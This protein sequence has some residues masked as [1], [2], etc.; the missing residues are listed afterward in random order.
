MRL[1]KRD[2]NISLGLKSIGLARI[3]LLLVLLSITLIM[4]VILHEQERKFAQVAFDAKVAD[5]EKTL[6]LRMKNYEEMLLGVAGLYE[7]SNS[8][9]R[10]EFHAYVSRLHILTNYVGVLGVGYAQWI[11]PENL[12]EHI[13]AVKAEGFPDFTVRPAGIRDHYTS[14][15]YIEP[16]EGRNLAAF[17]Y[18]MYSETVRRTAM[19]HAVSNNSTSLSAKVTLVQES[20]VNVQ[21]GMLMYHPVYKK[22]KPL[23]T[24]AQRWDALD[25]FAYSPFRVNDLMAAIIKD[26]D[27]DINFTIYASYSA[28]PD[29]K[30][31]SS[32]ASR[33]TYNSRFRKK[34]HMNLFGQVWTIVV[35]S[36]AQ[37]DTT[38]RN[39]FDEIVLVLGTISSFL[40]FFL[41]CAMSAQRQS[42]L[43]LAQS[44]SED[45]HEKN[46]QLQRSEERF[47]LALESSAMG[48]W[49]WNLVDNIIQ[50]DA[51]IHKLF[52][53][54]EH[55]PLNSYKSFSR[56]V[57]D[58]DRDRVFQEIADVVEGHKNYETQ[59]RV[60]WEDLSVHHIASRAK[61]IFDEH[62]VAV[63][64]IGTCWDITESKRLDKLKEEFVSTVSHELRTPLTAIT[65]ALGLVASGTLGELSA[66][67]K[68]ALD[69]AY[70]NA[71]RLKLLIN[72]LLDMD[73][74]L[75]GKLE[76][77]CEIQYVFSLI[78]R[79]VIENQSYADQFHVRY[80][81][82]PINPTYKIYVQ[83]VRFLQVMANFLSNAAKFS[84]AHTDVTISVSKVDDL[85]RISVS[86]K[87]VGL[88]DDAKK[89]MFEKFYQADS[90]DKRKKGGTGL[91]L[92]IA[93]EL[94]ERMHGH[95]GFTSE[96][97]VGSTF[98][99]EFPMAINERSV[100]K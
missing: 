65:G 4:Y 78:E 21:A 11:L 60:V 70:K 97:G 91:G 45:V 80:V 52:G 19:N 81:I 46:R 35:V 43:L 57:H 44:M 99:A 89:H 27:G 36:T 1:T 29:K 23:E 59:Y 79:A 83:D 30:I 34:I 26:R 98:Y 47:Q 13:Q 17:G 33:D 55:E 75:E 41:F 18:D 54:S 7:A 87:G 84:S 15:D 2:D 49:S 94:V 67:A 63:S 8:V 93:K 9:E 90:S 76:F 53:L 22:N 42:A 12:N 20:D 64:M 56:H 68:L 71:Q 31:Y 100:G 72:D 24:E 32:I 85:I 92:F 96:L 61:I 95:V 66:K 58:D 14:I 50:C 62:D 6:N 82:E 16:F 37:F 48:V 40:L 74:L 10:D 5:L 28:V 38:N 73:K 51:S 39:H 88:S 69:I 77:H 86:D 25:G 3:I